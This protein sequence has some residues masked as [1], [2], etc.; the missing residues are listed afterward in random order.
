[1]RAAALPALAAAVLAASGC[2]GPKA[3]FTV[4]TQAAPINL[5]LGARQAVETAPVG[6]IAGPLPPSAPFVPP[7]LPS[8]GPS[9]PPLPTGP[10][11]PCPPFDPLSPVQATSSIVTGKP[12]A[13]T[14]EYRGKV[15]DTAGT[16]KSVY[17]G[18]STWKVSVGEVDPSTGAFDLTTEVTLGKATTTRVFQVLTKPLV[19][20]GGLVGLAS[21]DGTDP[22]YLVGTQ[23]NGTL[24]SLGLPPLPKVL[25]N[26][27]RYGPAGIY[28]KS[29]SSG[30]STFAPLVP[31]P[32]LQTPVGNNSF[33]GMGTDG[34]TVMTFTS[35]VQKRAN[36]N[37]CGT[38]VEGTAVSI[39]GG[40]IAGLGADGKLQQVSFTENLVFGLQFGGLPIQDTGT[41]SSLT[42][43][44]AALAPDAATRDFSFTV[45][46]VP[47]P[48]K[49]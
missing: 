8:G 17:E 49:A 5:T 27:G 31:I 7:A 36:V 39:T 29:Q 33:T 35:T 30:G 16:A 43:P 21:P 34:S 2:A 28:L 42:V 22:N 6:P 40:L 18:N 32:L 9:L 25:P 12:Q 45:N 11:L 47:K 19:D 37:A 14:Y 10:A 3:P 46:T 13:A 4:G 1:M 41:I 48:A 26:P 23:V 15:V 24:V 44:G 38:K 20:D